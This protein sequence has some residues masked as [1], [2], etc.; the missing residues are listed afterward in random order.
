MNFDKAF[1]KQ[2]RL[3]QL[4]LLL[5]PGLNW[6]TEL[7]VRLSKFLRTRKGEDLLIMILG[8]LPTGIILGWLDFACVLL[9]N[10]LSFT[11]K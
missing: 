3:V 9:Y 10:R 6:I 2:S 7:L 1:N 8:F 4:V 11:K 5:I